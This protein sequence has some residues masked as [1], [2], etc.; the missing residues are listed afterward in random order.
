MAPADEFRSFIEDYYLL[1]VLDEAETRALAEKVYC[2][3]VPDLAGYETHLRQAGFTDLDLQDQTGPWSAFVRGRL[4][5]YRRD[6]TRQLALHGAEVVEGL[7]DF[8]ASVDRLFAGG[9]LGGLRIVARR[10]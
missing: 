8:Y 9:R 7:D 1:G 6:R 3:Y 10:P 4:A 5:G 2:P